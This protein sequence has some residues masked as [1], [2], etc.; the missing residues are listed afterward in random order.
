MNMQTVFQEFIELAMTEP[1]P[2]QVVVQ[3]EGVRQVAVLL[4][5]NGRQ[6][7]RLINMRLRA[8]NKPARE[9]TFWTSIHFKGNSLRA[10]HR[11]SELRALNHWFRRLQDVHAISTRYTFIP[12]LNYEDEMNVMSRIDTTCD[13]LLMPADHRL[14]RRY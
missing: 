8:A 6:L 11:Q 9:S 1:V 2:E 13:Q 12:P 4:P 14:S 10:N 3:G 5:L 7:R